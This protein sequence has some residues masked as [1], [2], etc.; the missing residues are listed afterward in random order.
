MNDDTHIKLPDK[1]KNSPF[2]V[3]NGYFDLLPEQIMQKCTSKKAEKISLWKTA[4]P[5]LS[6]A[7]GFLLLAGISKAILTVVTTEKT[8]SVNYLSQ[9]TDEEITPIL[10]ENE[11]SDEMKDEIISYLVDEHYIS[12]TFI[13]DEYIP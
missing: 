4:K 9:T 13:E 7:A 6:F 5:I 11:M 10:Y 1:L 3:P 8:E 12:M 2:S